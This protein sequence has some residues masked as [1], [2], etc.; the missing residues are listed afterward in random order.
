MPGLYGIISKQNIETLS[1]KL[2]L[3]HKSMEY[4]NF[5]NSD[6]YLDKEFGLA[7]SWSLHIDS[8][9]DC[10]PIF[11]ENKKILLFFFGENFIDNEDLN[12]LKG[13]NHIFN[14]YNAS[15]I[16]H[17]Y[18]EFGSLF[19]Q[20]LN[21]HFSGILLD[22]SQ[23]ELFLFN[24]RLGMQRLYYFQKGNDF[25]FSSELKA[26]L[27]VL[28]SFFDIDE[29]SIGELISLN[30]VLENRSLFK[31][32]F[33]LPPSSIWSFT[34]NH[35]VKKKEYFNPKE[36]ES[37]SWLDPYFF[38]EKLSY[39]FPKV[40]KKYFRSKQKVGISLTGG[41]DTRMILS[42]SS[43][44]K[45]KFPCYTFGSMYRDCHDVKIA[46]EVAKNIEQTHHTIEL[47]KNFLDHFSTFAENTIYI[48]D[49]YLDVTG[50]AELYVNKIARNIAPIRITGNYGS[51]IFR[52]VG[53]LKPQRL[54]SNIFN[55]EL[56]TNINL[57]ELT[58]SKLNRSCDLSFT[59]FRETPWLEHNRFSVEQ[60]QLS[61]RSP[62]HDIEL[63]KLFYRAPPSIRNNNKTSILLIKNNDPIL[64]KIP[65]DRGYYL[66][67]SL[68]TFFLHPIYETSFK[69]EYLYNYGM[70]HWLAKL[71][72][73]FPSNNL[74]NSTF[75]VHSKDN[76]AMPS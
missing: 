41:L 30:C 34:M 43:L 61:I 46:R 1:E 28:P 48:S 7:I 65:T 74:H 45:N 47:G 52:S 49:G 13:K 53:W 50:A 32:I 72:Y 17:L 54:I 14:K 19:P 42:C 20:K 11:N 4:E 58:L 2:F 39:I 75:G 60:S 21:G 6:Y 18:E 51:E 37:L 9:C 8:F 73:L 35:S 62:F 63:I 67:N 59:L 27:Y 44:S 33:L 68:K 71:D 25:Y 55:F 23:N 29:Q 31:N 38:Q 64:S 22:K 5:Y 70:P 36:L 3:M 24:D 57:A 69:L 40:L 26:I 16:V 56:S 10:L 15:Y 76:R 12:K 66:T